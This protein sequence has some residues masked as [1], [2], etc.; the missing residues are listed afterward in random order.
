MPVR[1]SVG[2][3]QSYRPGLAAVDNQQDGWIA[4]DVVLM[5]LFLAR[6]YLL[7]AD[8]TC[9]SIGKV[10]PDRIEAIAPC[11]SV[12]VDVDNYFFGG[13]GRELLE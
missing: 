5:R 1:T 9:V 13:R 12:L 6:L 3:Q 2:S 4:R 7:C 11:A 10:S 8:G